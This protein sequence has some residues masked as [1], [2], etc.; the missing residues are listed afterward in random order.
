[1]LTHRQ[2]QTLNFIKTYMR[3]NG[4]V[5][6]AVDDF[7]QALGLSRGGTHRLLRCLED[8]GKI[9]RWYRCARAIE[10]L[11]EKSPRSARPINSM[12]RLPLSHPSP[13]AEFFV[14]DDDTKSLKPMVRE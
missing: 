10:V 2:L 3:R 6:P 5:A 9:R 1:M 14:W 4:G 12:R 7:V 13:K 8:R 11:P